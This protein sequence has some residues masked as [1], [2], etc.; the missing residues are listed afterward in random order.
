VLPGDGQMPLAELVALLRA[1]Q[2]AGVISLE[3]EKLWHPYLP[4]LRTAMIQ[5]QAQPWFTAR[6]QDR[7]PVPATP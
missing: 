2:F 5:L 4:P 3:W 7:P 6:S 1:Q